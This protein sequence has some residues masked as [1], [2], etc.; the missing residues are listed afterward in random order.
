[1]IEREGTGELLSSSVL[2]DVEP[3]THYR[4]ETL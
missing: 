1:M 3:A 2:V 4:R